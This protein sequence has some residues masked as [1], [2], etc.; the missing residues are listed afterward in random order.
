M[1]GLDPSAGVRLALDLA[2]PVIGLVQHADSMPCTSGI[3][4]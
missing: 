2:E 1:M 3:G 4:Q